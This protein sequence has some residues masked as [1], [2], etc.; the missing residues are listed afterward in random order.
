MSEISDWCYLRKSRLSSITTFYF[1]IPMAVLGKLTFGLFGIVSW[2]DNN[3]RYVIKLKMAKSQFA[4][5]GQLYITTLQTV[6]PSLKASKVLCTSLTIL[7]DGVYKGTT[8]SQ[9]YREG[10]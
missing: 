10:E 3:G 1:A 9:R 4:K 8:P 2:Q 7:S 6:Q 5:H